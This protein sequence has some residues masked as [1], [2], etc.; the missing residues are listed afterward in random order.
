M[1]EYERSVI[2]VSKEIDEFYSIRHFSCCSQDNTQNYDTEEDD[3]YQDVGAPAGFAVVDLCLLE[4]IESVLGILLCDS[5]VFVKLL[6]FLTLRLGLYSYILCNRI[7]VAHDIGDVIDIG[8]PL[9][10]LG[11]HQI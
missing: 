9:L 8:L 5:H 6:E 7:Y 4:L 11:V 2:A 10:Y 3:A 1:S